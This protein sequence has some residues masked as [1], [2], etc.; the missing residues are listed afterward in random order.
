MRHDGTACGE[1]ACPGG[2]GNRFR[3]RTYYT[4]PVNACCRRLASSVKT[5]GLGTAAQ[6]DRLEI[7]WPNGQQQVFTALRANQFLTIEQEEDHGKEDSNGIDL[8]N[9]T[10]TP[11]H[12]PLDQRRLKRLASRRLKSPVATSP[13]KRKAEGSGTA[14]FGRAIYSSAFSDNWLPN[15]MFV[16]VVEAPPFNL[17][18]PYTG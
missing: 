16:A 4:I 11:S 9:L 18:S 13:S 17:K 5:P 10:W 7:T 15:A 1:R 6:I 14:L 8:G 12:G 2:C 3:S